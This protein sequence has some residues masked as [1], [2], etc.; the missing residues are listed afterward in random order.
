VSEAVKLEDA[1]VALLDE[2]SSAQ[3]PGCRHPP[4]RRLLLEDNLGRVALVIVSFE[5]EMISALD[6]VISACA[7]NTKAHVDVVT[8]HGATCPTCHRMRLPLG[9]PS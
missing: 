9:Y 3:R 1:L 7:G 6:D 4:T 8:D 2:V 5:P